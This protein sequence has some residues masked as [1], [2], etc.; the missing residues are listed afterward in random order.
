MG[1]LVRGFESHLFRH[2]KCLILLILQ[3]SEKRLMSH[4]DVTGGTMA[5]THLFRRGGM[6]WFVRSMPRDLHARHG[7]SHVRQSLRTADYHLARRKAA[8]MTVAMDDWAEAVRGAIE[9]DP[10]QP[11]R[12]LLLRMLDDA[13][14]LVQMERDVASTHQRA[15]EL[16]AATAEFV[17][18]KEVS[19][20]VREVAERTVPIMRAAEQSVPIMQG[21]AADIEAKAARIRDLEAI[22]APS[23]AI[24]DLR[25]EMIE[26][27]AS[28]RSLVLNAHKERWSEK[29][30]SSFLPA[31][32]EEKA[33]KLKESKHA[34][35]LE[36]RIRIFIRTIGDKA[37]RDY[38]RSDFERFRDLLDRTPSR[39]EVRF[40]T[41]DM[42]EAIRANDGMTRPVPPMSPTTVDDGYLS[43]VKNIFSWLCARQKIERNSGV[44]VVSWRTDPQQRPDEQRLPFQPDALS[45]YLAHTVRTRSRATPD[46]WMPILALYTGARLNELCQIDPRRIIQRD[47]VWLLDLLTI[48]DRDEIDRMSETDRLRIKS[49]AGRREIPLHDDLIATGFLDF[50]RERERR[51]RSGGRLFSGVRP[52]AYGYYS[53][54]ISKRLNNDIVRAGAKSDRVSF[55]SL[56]HNFRDA[57]RGVPVPDRLA[58]RVMGHLVPGAQGH[59]GSP[60]LERAEIDMIRKIAFPGVDISPYID[61]PPPR[62]RSI[63]RKATSDGS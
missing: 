15:T 49:A 24:A 60:S 38:D 57:L 23:D 56:R 25:R 50:V 40:K 9:G 10:D 4:L 39:W 32:L 48:F 22:H 42:A 21:M 6:W 61:G 34:S 54:V 51:N 62:R 59:Y 55:Y 20:R 35:T 17:A 33:K 46:Y 63:R 16:R 11:D 36:P 37:V 2:R 52:D 29:P 18:V 44:G 47:G 19:D 12:A 27:M 41:D 3:A 14:T 7:C 43:P 28:M 30:L 53:T 45:A 13:M 58:D 8:R 1:Q 31:Y 5:R 26:S